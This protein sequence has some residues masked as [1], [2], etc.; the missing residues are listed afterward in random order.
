ME[1]FT[2]AIPAVTHGARRYNRWMASPKQPQ[3]LV[4]LG[5][6][7]AV[8]VTVALG[9]IESRLRGKVMAS[10][11]WVA[12]TLEVERQFDRVLLATTDAETGQRG[13][14]LAR[15]TTYL[16][17]Y[18]TARSIVNS[19]I[20]ALVALTADNPSQQRRLAGLTRLV[21]DKFLEL[22]ETVDLAERGDRDG[23][24]VLLASNRGQDLM[25][26][27]RQ[28]AEEGIAEEERLLWT[29]NTDLARSIRNGGYLIWGLILLNAIALTGLLLTMRRLQRLQPM[30]RVCAW[31]K[32]IEFQNEWITFEEY[33]TR[34]FHVRVTHGISPAQAEA[35]MA[36]IDEE[37][38]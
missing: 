13:F 11:G 30:A 28:N 31:S 8:M 35:L 22:K 17:P 1:P 4:I 38:V 15:N 21:E 24:V 7:L 12:H 27:I 25:T 33:L 19:Q 3:T 26:R 23:A 18:E 20:A 29:R 16:T 32:T 6:S 9:A 14:L 10:A 37:Q 36:Q 2:N 5:V 34:R